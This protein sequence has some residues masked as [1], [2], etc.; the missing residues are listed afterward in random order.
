MVYLKPVLPQT[1]ERAEAFLAAPVRHWRDI[2]TPLTGTQIGEYQPLATRVD[3]AALQKLVEI[4]M[5]TDDRKPAAPEVT[6]EISAE[7][8]ARIDLRVARIEAASL[9][10]GADRL[11]QLTV[12]LG[13]ERRT[14]FAGIRGAYQPEQLVGR[15]VVVVANMKPRKLRFGVSEGMALAATGDGGPFLIVPDAGATPGMKVS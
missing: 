2:D 5:T 1:A 4:P 7:Q 9:V 10:E 14:V 15:L 3:P 13:G 6:A 12:D 8:F 11:L